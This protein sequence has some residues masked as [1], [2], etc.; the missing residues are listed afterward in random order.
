MQP[1]ATFKPLVLNPERERLVKAVY[2]ALN[3][4]DRAK[5]RPIET[6]HERYPELTKAYDDVYARFNTE[7]ASVGLAE[8]LRF[9][10]LDRKFGLM[11]SDLPIDDARS[12]YQQMESIGYPEINSL[13]SHRMIWANRLA[14]EG[15]FE[16]AHTVAKHLFNDV[17]AFR[18]LYPN[19]LVKDIDDD[20]ARFRQRIGM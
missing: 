3:D 13:I 14:E 20:L 12:L 4:I 17:D 2:S 9:V 18:K 6:L 8:W 11:F 19:V 16:E 10:I 5:F 7:A 1:L 15:E